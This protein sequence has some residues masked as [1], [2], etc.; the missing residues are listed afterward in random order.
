MKIT[1]LYGGRSA[2]HEVSILSAF[3]VLNAIYYNYYQVQLV[4]I[5]KEGQ[6]VKGPLL[7][8]KPASKDVLHLSWDPSGQTEEGFTG[9]V[10]NPGEIKEEG[11]IVFPVLHGPKRGRWN[12][13]RLLRD[14]EYA[15]CRRRRIDQ[16]MCH[17]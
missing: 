4:F 3:S 17:G 11:A 8:E 14:I 9:K 16:C 1:L 6:W 13:P 10:I 7:T 12:D 15:L 5:T 2:E